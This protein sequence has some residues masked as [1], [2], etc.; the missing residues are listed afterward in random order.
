MWAWTTLVP[1]RFLYFSLKLICVALS[2][3]ALNEPVPVV[4]CDGSSSHPLRLAEKSLLAFAVASVGEGNRGNG[5]HANDD[6]EPEEYNLPH[7]PSLVGSTE[8]T[9]DHVNQIGRRGAPK[10]SRGQD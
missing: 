1:S 4:T 6:G 9:T 2:T 5:E 10:G 3:S 7:L 8:L